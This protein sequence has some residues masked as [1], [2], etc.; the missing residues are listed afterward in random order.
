MKTVIL[1]GYTIVLEDLQWKGFHEIGQAEY[2]DRC[3]YSQ[4]AERIKGADCILTSKVE[5]DGD[6]MDSC[7]ELRYIGVLATGYNNVDVAAAAERG[8]A[9]TNIP[10][11]STNAVSEFVFAAILDNYRRVRETGAIVRE[12]GWVASRDFC[13]SPFAQNEL[14]G[15]TIGVVGFGNIGRKVAAI[16]N[17]FGM[18]VLINSRTKKETD[19][20]EFT[21]LEDLLKRSDIVTLHCPLTDESR[22]LINSDALALMKNDALLINCARGPIVNEEDLAEGLKKGIIGAAV[23][24]VLEKEPMKEGHPLLECPNCLMTPHCS[25]MSREAREKIVTVSFENLKAFL[26]GKKLNRIV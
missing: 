21:D 14:F 23:L 9:V 3:E 25:W 18:K 10:A 22:G 13:F 7:P 24:D 5:I 6:I 1:D 17:A 20:G 26:D 4:V 16:A 11:Y 12:G 8:I 19:L 15:K 2:Y